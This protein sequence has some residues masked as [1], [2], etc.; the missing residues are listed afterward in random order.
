MSGA[1]LRCPAADP[2][3]YCTP[4]ILTRSPGSSSS[5]SRSSNWIATTWAARGTYPPRAS[6]TTGR[7]HHDRARHHTGVTPR[8]SR[9]G[10]ALTNA[11]RLHGS[12]M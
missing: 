2:V 1:L 10:E 8:P 5:G 12:T 3:P 11:H 6:F 9:A 4:S 7:A